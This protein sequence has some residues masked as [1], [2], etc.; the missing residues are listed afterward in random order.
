VRQPQCT[1]CL[2]DP[3]AFKGVLVRAA[4]PL[5]HETHTRGCSVR[6]VMVPTAK[7][8]KLGGGPNSA[9][10]PY[11]QPVTV[12][13]A[14]VSSAAPVNSAS[15]PKYAIQ[16]LPPAAST[17]DGVWFLSGVSML[18]PFIVPGNMQGFPKIGAHSTTAIPPSGYGGHGSTGYDLTS[19]PLAMNIPIPDFQDLIGASNNDKRERGVKRKGRQAESDREYSSKVP[20]CGFSSHYSS[21][22]AQVSGVKTSVANKRTGFVRQQGYVYRFECQMCDYGTDKTS[23]FKIHQDMHAG[24]RY[25]C[26]ECSREFASSWDL[27][28]HIRT[29]H[30]HHEGFK[31]PKCTKTF[32]RQSSVKRHYKQVHEGVRF[33]CPVSDCSKLYTGRA[34]CVAHI[35]RSHRNVGERVKPPIRR[36][37]GKDGP[38]YMRM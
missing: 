15:V 16:K 22:M 23:A 17:L 34:D 36:S 25:P 7:K 19:M 8:Q 31:C 20:S 9:F 4:S 38:K 18:P 14:S 1:P 21:Y 24:V 13:P 6:I 5:A 33:Q 11:R 3:A 35:K 32:G 37:F 10:R 30:N 29:T 26:Y 2:L 27:K 28:R 12:A